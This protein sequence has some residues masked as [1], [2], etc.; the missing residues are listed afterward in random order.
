MPQLSYF[1]KRNV[2]KQEYPQL[3]ILPSPHFRW[4][5][6]DV[7]HCTTIIMHEMRLQATVL[8]YMPPTNAIVFH[9]SYIRAYT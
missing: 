5:V 6:N 4:V 3:P 7:S 2:V 8:W 9:M 1:D